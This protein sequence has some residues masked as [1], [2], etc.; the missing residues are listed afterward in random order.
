MATYKHLRSSTA[1]KRPTTS[2]ADGQ[3]AINTNTASPGLFFKD[4]AGTGIVKVGPVHV[5]STAPNSTPAAGGSSGNYLGEQWLDT[6]ASPAQMKV[7]NGSAWVGVVADELPV[8]KLQDGDAR[9]LLQTDAAGTG[10][11]WT[12]N[13][14]VPGTLDVTGAATFDSI[15]RHPLGTAG[16]PTVTFTGDTNTG[17]YSPGADQVAISTN[18]AQA[19]YIN[20][21]GDIL[22]ADGNRM[23]IDEIRAR[24]GAG[25]K[26][27]DDGG[28]G[29]F[30][31]DGG[32][33]GLGTSSPAGLLECV[34][35]ASG[36]NLNFVFKNFA[37]ATNSASRLVLGTTTVDPTADS[38][39]GRSI[40]SSIRQGD[41]STDLAF[42]LSRG[43]A[44]TQD[45]VYIDGSGGRVGIG[46]TSPAVKFHAVDTASGSTAY[47][48]FQNEGTGSGSAV[49]LQFYSGS[50]T[51]NRFVSAIVA[52][53]EGTASGEGYLSFHT[54]LSNTV[55]EKARID[56]SGRL[57]VGTSTGSTSGSGNKALLQ[58][59]GS[60]CKD[61]KNGTI[62]D[63][64]T[65]TLFTV[66]TFGVFLV[67]TKQNDSV[68]TRSTVN[69]V[70]VNVS[71]TGTR[72]VSLA[73]APAGGWSVAMSGLDFQ[74]TN[75]SGAARGYSASIL[76]LF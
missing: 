46:T 17:I 60:V 56:S 37:T 40:I 5:G 52:D 69:L 21:D 73:A 50:S 44:V 43:S 53:A 71:G 70:F 1:N 7:W 55:T 59:N 61:A 11:Q 58:V 20:A 42:N 32:N 48:R 33:V 9:Q 68:T 16:A 12:S 22:V 36:G 72:L 2:I 66:H 15:A 25:L 51:S 65:L 49:G 45:V 74:L 41:G 14:D 8:S 64:Q 38:I 62:S 10:V 13:V 39:N 27:F 75:T 19:L 31:Q 23:E 63:G 4:S 30:I 35:V 67:T 34:G 26:L 18:G 6:G 54:R 29:I 3:L 47:F 76:Q 24:D 28:A 57:L